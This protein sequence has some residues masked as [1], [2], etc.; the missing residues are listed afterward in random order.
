MVEPA[1]APR[2]GL[3]VTCL[4]DLFR[5]SVGFAAAKLIEAAGC[6][7][8]VPRLQ[9][10]CGQ[11]AYNAGGRRDAKDIAKQ[12]IA[13]FEE[14]DY[15]VVPSGSCAGMIKEHY[16]L[17]LADQPEWAQRAKALAARTHELVSFLYDIRGMRAVAARHQGV[18]TYHDA[19]SGLRELGIKVQ[20]RAL[21]ASVADLALVELPGAEICCG[22]GGTFCVKYPDISDKMVGAKAEDIVATGATTLLAGDLGCLLNMA[23]KLKRDGHKV[24]VR[25]VA[26]VL[27]GA[28]ETA[29]IGE[30]RR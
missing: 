25:H 13:L 3:F 11:P 21:L 9:T 24:A 4:I 6:A 22:F 23:G 28:T 27:A 20:P 7:L 26:E 5:P 15:T 10:C 18:A 17:L 12:T 1:S 29:P 16:P 8:A 2:V 19:C 14:F 30:R